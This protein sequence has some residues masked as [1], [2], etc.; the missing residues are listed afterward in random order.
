[1]EADWISTSSLGPPPVAKR[2]EAESGET[3]IEDTFAPDGM[4]LG[5]SPHGEKDWG[6]LVW[7]RGQFV[8]AIAPDL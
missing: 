6:W 1:M 2:T 8:S 7:S 4:D 5:C 3:E